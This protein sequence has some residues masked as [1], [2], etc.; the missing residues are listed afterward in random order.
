M[1][2]GTV[3]AENTVGE[4]MQD[5]VSRTLAIEMLD[6]VWKA[7]ESLTLEALQSRFG[8]SRTVAR[9]VAKTLESMNAVLVKRRIGL[10][11]R[12]F[13]EWQ[14]LNHQVIE[15]RLLFEICFKRFFNFFH[16]GRIMR[17]VQ[18]N[19]RIFLNFF[20]STRPPGLFQGFT[21]LSPIDFDSFDF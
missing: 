21:S 7:G 9:E 17:A 10:V 13:G 2:E 3:I 18:N 19:Q 11:A 20:K 16:S 5:S 15:W 4:L 14:A 6:G 1:A 12:P 8:I